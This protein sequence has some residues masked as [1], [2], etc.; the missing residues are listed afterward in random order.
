MSSVNPWSSAAVIT[1]E[2]YVVH[3]NDQNK[4]N[5]DRNKMDKYCTWV[6]LDTARE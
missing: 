6:I 2:S 1:I 3:K 4:I 5:N